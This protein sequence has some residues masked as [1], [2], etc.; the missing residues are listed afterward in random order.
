M[1]D[2]QEHE[3]LLD[4]YTEQVKYFENNPED[5]EKLT[6]IGEYPLSQPDS[7]KNTAALTVAIVTIYNLDETITKS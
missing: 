4:Y 1:P 2:K 5:A 3:I 7:I 6:K